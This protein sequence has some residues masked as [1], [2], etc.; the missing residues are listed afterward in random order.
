VVGARTPFDVDFGDVK[1]ARY[2]FPP[3][4]V[5]PLQRRKA[6][7]RIESAFMSTGNV[8]ESLIWKQLVEVA[9]EGDEPRPYD[10]HDERLGELRALL[11]LLVGE[12]VIPTRFRAVT[13]D[14]RPVTGSSRSLASQ[15]RGPFTQPR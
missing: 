13:A 10:W 1:T 11:G 7:L 3:D 4:I 2:E 15:A 5:V 14:K 8:F 9:I 6:T 12:P